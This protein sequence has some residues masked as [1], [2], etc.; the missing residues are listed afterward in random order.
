MNVATLIENFVSKNGLSKIKPVYV[1]NQ[2]GVADLEK[3]AVLEGASELISLAEVSGVDLADFGVFRNDGYRSSNS[4][5]REFQS[6]DWYVQRGREASRNGTQLNADMMQYDLRSEPWRN[7]QKG[8]KDHYD[9]LIVH[10]DM[11]SGD[12]HFVIGVAE[13]G[14]GT[15]ISTHRFKELNDRARYECIKTEIMHELGHVFGLIPDARTLNVEYSL[16]KH[17]SNTCTMRQGLRVPDDW[18]NITND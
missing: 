11:Y 10:D 9:I 5:L 15:T 14:I 8:G 4:S 13:R 18:I 16:G 17:C 1:M 2:A 12:T 3:Q 6:V 7:P